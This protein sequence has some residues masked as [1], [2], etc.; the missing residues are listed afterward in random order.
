MNRSNFLKSTGLLIFLGLGIRINM[1][2]ILQRDK[3]KR[4]HIYKSEHNLFI[5]K[6]ISKNT[7]FKSSMRLN[8]SIILFNLSKNNF[9]NRA[10]NRCIF[11]YRKSKIHSSFR[12]SRLFFL[13]VSR[14][15]LISGLKK[16]CW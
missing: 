7:L 6:N 11:T 13:K 14:F 16:S 10:V 15:G 1:K 2:S 5:I 3:K 8:T 9:K 4:N 12:F